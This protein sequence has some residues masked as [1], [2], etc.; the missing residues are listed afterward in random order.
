MN[1]C[2]SFKYVAVVGLLLFAFPA[3]ADPVSVRHV[4]GS[5]HGFV[6]LKDSS[7]KILASGDVTQFPRGNSVTTVFSLHFK[8][9][10]LYEETS[11]FSQR[12]TFQ[13]LR[14]KQ[15][16]KGPAFKTSQTLSLDASTGNVSIQY[17]DKDGKPK[18]VTDRLLLP[19]DLSNGILPTLLS[20][21]DPKAET[22][23]SMLVSTPKLRVVKLKIS[24]SGED[25]FSIGGAIAKAT[26]YV[27][28]IDIGGV[29]GVAAKLIGK[30]PPPIHMWIAAGNAPIFLRSDGPL[31]EDGPIWRIELASPIW[32]KD[33]AKR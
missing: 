16:Q 12:K 31:F 8:D 13:L 3:E 18:S 9:G 10:S 14:Y 33:V 24:A 32:P 19:V 23:L 11:V 26:H 28:K 30:Q 22:T 15:V 4:Q 29:T 6:V 25:S 21:V 27:V 5:I 1:N 20:S 2:G 7:E 17:I